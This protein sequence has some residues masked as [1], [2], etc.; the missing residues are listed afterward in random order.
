MICYLKKNMKKIILASSSPRRKELM[1]RL[2]ND[3][4][5]II[6]SSYEE[7]NNLNIDPKEMA[8]LHSLEKAK[9][10][11]RNNNGIIIGADTIVVYGNKVLG[12]PKDKEDA[13][14]M[15]K[16]ISGKYVDVISGIAIVE[17]DK[18]IN[19]YEITKVKMK[20]MTEK[21][22]EAYVNTGEPM[23]KSGAYGAQEKGAVLIEKIEGCY[24]NVVGLPLFKLHNMLKDFNISIF[25]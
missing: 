5:Q 19:D 24:F 25:D 7:D 23:D 20:Q 11:A 15:L 17:G 4:F 22:I 8:M 6:T 3:N 21:E 18:E 13:K 16:Y 14:K 10:V 9:D 2:F 1:T 12:K